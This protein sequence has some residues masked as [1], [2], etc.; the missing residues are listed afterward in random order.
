MKEASKAARAGRDAG[1]A[2]LQDEQGSLQAFIEGDYLHA[3]DPVPT[4]V[5]GLDR[6]LCGGLRPG[7]SVLGGEPGA[8]KSALA[9][10]VA[11]MAA[12]SG[13]RVL[14]ASLEMGRGQCLMRLLSLLS[15]E[16]W[17]DGPGA[18]PFSWADAHRLAPRARQALE[19]A[20]GCGEPEPAV[21]GRLARGGDPVLTAALGLQ[22]TC[23]GL[24]VAAG[25]QVRTLGGLEALAGRA[26]G[27]GASLAVVDYLQLV[28][29]EGAQGMAEYERVTLVSSRLNA[30][31]CDLGVP[32]LA[33]SAMS[34]QSAQAAG[35]SM[36]GFKGSGGIEYDANAAMVIE[37]DGEAAPGPLGRPVLL[38]VVKDRW[39]AL[40]GDSPV[41]LWFDGAHNRLEPR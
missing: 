9:L 26:A 22:K 30:L 1:W 41:R 7:L 37:G 18:A 2:A 12:F 34:R 16:P 17:A 11:F 29:P 13:R 8:G 14:F 35:P 6:V 38:H 4:G 28:S 3:P 27:L 5:D 15:T 36:H 31:G 21:I 10:Q 19:D 25:P 23:P 20:R 40:T 24:L 33:L 39:G 32:V